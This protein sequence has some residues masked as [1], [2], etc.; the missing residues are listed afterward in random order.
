MNVEIYIVNE[1]QL[2]ILMHQ[3]DVWL[4]VISCGEVREQTFKLRLRN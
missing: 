2:N 1:E 4:S 3:H